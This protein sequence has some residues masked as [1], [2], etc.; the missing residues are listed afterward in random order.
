[1]ALAVGLIG[2][3]R[4]AP[5]KPLPPQKEA[6]AAARDAP[7]PPRAVTG[8]L[9][10]PATPTT[11]DVPPTEFAHSCQGDAGGLKRDPVPL[12]G[13]MHA[14]LR[15]PPVLYYD[16]LSLLPAPL[17]CVIQN[18]NAWIEIRI[19]G[20]LRLPRTFPGIGFADETVLL[21]GLGT[22]PT[23]GY[24]VRFDSVAVRH[25]TLFAFVGRTVPRSG[26]VLTAAST[27]PVVVLR[28]PKHTGPVVFVEQ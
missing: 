9:F 8:Y 20:R 2:C 10:A 25:D 22:Q 1:M 14:A 6:R 21:A 26:S 11:G 4:D 5:P 19:L 3:G 12:G 24:A 27:S 16:T 17:R 7:P 15:L 23:A 13:P 28:V 18:Q